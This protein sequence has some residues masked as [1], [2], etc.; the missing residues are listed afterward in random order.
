MGMT[1]AL[2]VRPAQNKTG[3]GGLPLTTKYAYNDAD[4]TTRYDREFGFMLGE[5]FAEG[6]YR[7]AHIQT[8]DWTDYKA[9]FS[10]MNGRTYPDT[11]VGNGSQSAA[12]DLVA[13]DPDGRLQYQP[14]TSLV[15]C[16]AGERVLLRLSS[17][18]YINH[19]M[20]VDNLDLTVVAKDASLLRGANGSNQY[21][22]T[23]TIDVGP[24]ESR[25]VIF[26]APPFS[27]SRP[28]ATDANGTFNSY[29][30]YDRDYRGAGNAGGANPG[31]MMTQIRVYP[32]ATLGAQA[33]PQTTP[34]A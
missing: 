1:G 10:T 7:D 29:L 3:W 32:A 15:T 31:G 24:G 23:N 14:I 4:G 34:N 26:T 11:L 28:T 17:L 16:N 9:S 22:H 19:A 12:G 8:S 13:A 33:D 21:L 20:T 18:G 27:T 2:F 30:L 5:I 6:H 25:D